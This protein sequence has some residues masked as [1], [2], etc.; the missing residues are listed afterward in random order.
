MRTIL[1]YSLFLTSLFFST[2]TF[3]QNMNDQKQIE[4]LLTSFFEA[5]NKGDFSGLAKPFDANAMF[6]YLYDDQTESENLKDFLHEM[7][8]GLTHGEPNRQYSVSDIHVEI[9]N[10]VAHA[11][12]TSETFYMLKG[13]S[14]TVSMHCTLLKTKDEWKIISV[15]FGNK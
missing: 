9:D 6:F 3:S 1:A 2:H 7:E 12:A 4:T 10:N 5:K 13:N 14:H 15:I 11:T 8:E